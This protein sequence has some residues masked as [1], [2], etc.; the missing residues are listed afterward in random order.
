M[1]SESFTSGKVILVNHLPHFR[2]YVF[3]APAEANKGAE[4]P[5]GLSR[6]VL[7]ATNPPAAISGSSKGRT[8]SGRWPE[9]KTWL[10]GKPAPKL[11]SQVGREARELS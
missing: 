7:D 9:T 8:V 3:T 1:E 4:T 10:A 11:P 6:A 2:G 5:R